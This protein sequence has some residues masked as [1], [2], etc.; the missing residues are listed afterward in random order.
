MENE[1]RKRLNYLTEEEIKLI[2]KIHGFNRNSEDFKELS[3]KIKVIQAEEKKVRNKLKAVVATD[4]EIELVAYHPDRSPE[5]LAGYGD[6][7]DICLC[8]NHQTI[9]RIFYGG[10]HY[11]SIGN[12]GYH[13]EP[14]YRGHNYAA[15]AT[16][17]LNGILKDIGVE[18]VFVAVDKK[19]I[20]SIKTIE[21]M[22]GEIIDVNNSDPDI[23]R[24]ICY[25]GREKQK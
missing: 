23:V 2:N 4:G 24:Y 19:N 15:K 22:G 21:K 11:I 8:E 12:V 1:L 16:K 6:R 20:P 7:Y 3:N 9:G 10:N 17:L 25:T 14:E 13:I 5:K 18:S